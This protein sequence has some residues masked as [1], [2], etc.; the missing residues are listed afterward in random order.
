MNCEELNNKG[1][2]KM[3]MVE[4]VN[5]YFENKDF[6]TKGNK[7]LSK[8]VYVIN[9][10][11]A[12]ECPSLQ[13]GLCNAYI[14]DK[15]ICYAIKSEVRYGGEDGNCF[16][17]HDY[18]GIYYDNHSAEEITDKLLASSKRSTKYPMVFLRYNAFGD[19]VNQEQVDKMNEIAKIL[20]EYGIIT[21]GY[22][23]RKDLN[24]SNRCRWFIVNGSGFMIDNN[25][26]I[27]W[28]E[29]E[30]DCLSNKKVIGH[31]EDQHYCGKECVKCMHSTHKTIH[32]MGRL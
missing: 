28:D 32:E 24:F 27:T 1:E 30:V 16:K 20:G 13:L 22:T 29:D 9:T 18:Q 3:N 26:D 21:Y 19:F 14:D 7:K 15:C 11:S 25:F 10:S 6:F 2:D 23:A 5:E 4:I 31:K 8:N 17:F 12:L